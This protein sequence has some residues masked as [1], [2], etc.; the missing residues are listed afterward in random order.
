MSGWGLVN[1]VSA[2]V[3][4]AV[5]HQRRVRVGA[6]YRL[7]SSLW[8]TWR[9]KIPRLWKPVKGL[10]CEFMDDLQIAEIYR[11]G[12][13]LSICHFAADSLSLFTFTQRA[14]KKLHT[15]RWCV[16]VWYVQSS[17]VITVGS[18][19]KP[20]YDFLLVFRCNNVLFYS[21][22]LRDLLVAFY[23]RFTDPV[24][25]EAIVMARGYA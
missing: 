11:P 19:R 5:A 20:V 10:P 15:A 8:V 23:R 22:R 18:I 3:R 21:F 25:F 2:K 14:P 24:S 7:S 12:A 16:A 9:W 17:K 13:R 4:E 1:W 6:L